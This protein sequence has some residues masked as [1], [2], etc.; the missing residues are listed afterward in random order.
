MSK[1][2]ADSNRDAKPIIITGDGEYALP[3]T[4]CGGYE[5]LNWNET[6]DYRCVN[7]LQRFRLRHT[8]G[9]ERPLGSFYD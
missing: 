7:C 8:R 6:A 4:H 1:A 3:E 2:I 5:V 9:Y